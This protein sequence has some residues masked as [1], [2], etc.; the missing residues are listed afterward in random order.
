MSPGRI[1]SSLNRVETWTADRSWRQ[2][3]CM[4]GVEGRVG[5]QVILSE[6]FFPE[7]VAGRAGK[8]ETRNRILNRRIRLK[9]HSSYQ[10]VGVDTRDERSLRRLHGLAL[11]DRGQGND[12]VNCQPANGCLLPQR[13]GD[14]PTEL[15]HHRVDE[16]IR[17]NLRIELVGVR[18]E[19]ALE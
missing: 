19:V 14:V 13:V 8:V 4:V 7:A 3:R 2:T 10:T 5:L 16:L 11:N 18:K 6:R 15:A 17:S 1:G 12:L 9:L